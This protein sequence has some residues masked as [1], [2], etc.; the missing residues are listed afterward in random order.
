MN[1]YDD[2]DYGTLGPKGMMIIMLVT[3][4]CS[5]MMLMMMIERIWMKTK[6]RPIRLI[7]STSG[8]CHQSSNRVITT[9]MSM[10]MI[11]ILIMVMMV[12][13]S[14]VIMIK[15]DMMMVMTINRQPVSFIIN[16]P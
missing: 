2:D 3:L 4:I 15:N 7:A 16:I 1:V 13:I 6:Q 9:M 10:I 11:S 8:G 12:M 14:I 5:N